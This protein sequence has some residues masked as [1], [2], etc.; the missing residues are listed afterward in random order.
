VYTARKSVH[1]NQEAPAH[2]EEYFNVEPFYNDDEAEKSLFAAPSDEAACPVRYSS[3]SG[4]TAVSGASAVFSGET[5]VSGAAAVF[6]GGYLPAAATTG[7]SSLVPGGQ[8]AVTTPP[9]VAVAAL[10]SVREP[11]RRQRHLADFFCTYFYLSLSRRSF[12]E[13]KAFG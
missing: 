6:S 9:E 1:P 2:L 5:A 10:A 11:G 8:R 12:F 7:I 13:Y 4:E 3:F